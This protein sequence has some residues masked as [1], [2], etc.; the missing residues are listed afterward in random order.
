[1]SDLQ[2]F[3]YPNNID[4]RSRIPFLSSY[5]LFSRQLLLALMFSTTCSYAEETT[6]VNVQHTDKTYRT[7]LSTTIHASPDNLFKLLTAYS[8]LDTLSQ[9]IHKSQL[10]PNG[11]L[12]LELRMCFTIICFAK[13]QTL[14]VTVARHSVTARIIREQSD[15]ESG[16]MKWQLS[17]A[18]D[19]GSSLFY[20]SAEMVPD[21]WVPPLIGPLL[22]QHKLK[23]E[24]HYS[25]RQ[26]ENLALSAK[27]K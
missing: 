9:T 5:R 24:A 16:W 12:F 18:K 23:K 11:H 26:L 2:V 4:R 3:L 13:Q 19:E 8:S 17:P 22:I 15:F 20:F 21:F 10:L 7:E 25:I 6:L 1:M 14:E 27:A